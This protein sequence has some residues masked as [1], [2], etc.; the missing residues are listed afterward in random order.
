MPSRNGRQA[1][2]FYVCGLLRWHCWNRGDA[3]GC[4]GWSVHRRA[5]GV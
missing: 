2:A 4:H 1:L 5:R 3:A